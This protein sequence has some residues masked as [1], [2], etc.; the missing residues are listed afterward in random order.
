MKNSNSLTYVFALILFLSTVIISCNSKETEF[1]ETKWSKQRDG[2][3]Q[4]RE[5]M[6][7]DLIAN[8]LHKGM[9]HDEIVKLLGQPENYSDLD[10][11]TIAYEIM[12]D[13]GWNIDPVETKTL[14][15][16]F[17]SDSL[18]AGG[19]VKHWKN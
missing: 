3:Y 16:R 6:T 4:Y 5:M 7:A 1:N 8:H 11:N 17:S 13:Y 14:I 15:L 2:S 12:V 9:H 18:Y 10:A 19:E